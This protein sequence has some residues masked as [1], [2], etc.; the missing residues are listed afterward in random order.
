[1]TREEYCPITN[2]AFIVDKEE[3]ERLNYQSRY[4]GLKN[5]RVSKEIADSFEAD[6]YF[7]RDVL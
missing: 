2:I 4:K 3:N 6:L 7:S 1:M 5:N